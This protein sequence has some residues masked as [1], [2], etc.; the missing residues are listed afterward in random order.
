[1][2]ALRKQEQVEVTDSVL[3][4]DEDRDLTLSF[5]RGDHDAY[6]SIYSRYYRSVYNVC[7]RML[8]QRDDAQEATQETFLRVYQALGRFNGHYQLGPWIIR[9][10]TNVCLDHLRLRKRRPQDVTPIDALEQR[11]DGGTDDPEQV[12]LK[13]A[14]GD[15]IRAVLSSLPPA[16]RAAIVLRDY[17][18]MPYREIALTLD[19]SEGQVKAL[20]HRARKRFRRTW[21]PAPVMLPL[22][23]FL[24]RFRGRHVP[25]GPAD[26]ARA[27]S[28]A[29]E[30]AYASGSVTSSGMLEHVSVAL[31]D[32]VAPVVAAALIGAS[33]VGGTIAIQ[34]GSGE[35][36]PRAV[37]SVAGAEPSKDRGG[38]GAAEDPLDPAGGA[39]VTDEKNAGPAADDESGAPEEPNGTDKFK[40]GSV[41]DSGSGFD[42]PEVAGPDDPELTPGSDPEESPTPGSDPEE[43]PTPAPTESPTP[44]PTASPTPDLTPTPPADMGDEPSSL[45]LSEPATSPPPADADLG[46]GLSGG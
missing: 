15:K 35:T 2:A 25:F 20:L 1:M 13:R 41:A 3:G 27:A 4:S 30:I 19:I 14:E 22:Y 36:I 39:D 42:T 11:P 29:A 17:E 10:A 21:V 31:G 37:A 28:P 33:A 26:V 8:G 7:Y 32:K 40:G 12:L 46:D 6:G 45:G 34:G 24:N 43:S 5:Q 38:S 18:G 16:H 23:G 44:T 9:I